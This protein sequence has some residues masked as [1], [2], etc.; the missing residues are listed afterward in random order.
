M[1]PSELP[2][3]SPR[4]T[5]VQTERETHEAWGQLSMRQPAASALL[6]FF[7]ARVSD[8]NAVVI[9]QRALAK[10]TGMSLSTVKRGLAVLR[11]GQW[12]EVRRIGPTGTAA[13]YV[14][15]DRPGMG[16]VM[17]SDTAYSAPLLSLMLTSKT[18][19]R[20]SNPK[21]R[22]AN[23]QSSIEASGSFL[24]EKGWPRPPNP[25]SQAWNPISQQSTLTR[26]RKPGEQ[27]TNRRHEQ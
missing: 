2:E 7:S 20:N 11:E 1:N 13:A 4:G 8:H 25:P 16:A 10:A 5:W 21:H 14:L 6:H 17:G 24:Q 19:N 23:S 9:S 3:K 26:K 12:I 27:L 15:N 22:F 18:I